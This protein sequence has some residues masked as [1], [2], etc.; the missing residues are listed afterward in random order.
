[1]GCLEHHYIRKN[2][3]FLSVF[4]N[5]SPIKN[6]FRI[7]LLVKTGLQ[8]DELSFL[9][10][11]ELNH[12]Y[13]LYQCFSNCNPAKIISMSLVTNIGI[14]INKKNFVPLFYGIK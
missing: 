10:N 5:P 1:L 7:R 12:Y 13:V 8:P 6:N 4:Q 2:I 11:I 9:Q 3:P 14:L